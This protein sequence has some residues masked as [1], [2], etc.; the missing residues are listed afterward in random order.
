[1]TTSLKRIAQSQRRRAAVEAQ[2]VHDVAAAD[3]H[4]AVMG[5]DRRTGQASAIRS[6]GSRP[7]VGH[8]AS[9]CQTAEEI[10]REAVAHCTKNRD[11]W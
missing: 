4:D 3:D 6:G 9:P 5:R 2:V 8:P 10:A 11:T 7:L 1:L